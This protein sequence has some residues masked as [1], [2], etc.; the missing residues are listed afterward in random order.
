MQDDCERIRKDL[1]ELF[2]HAYG[3]DLDALL[4]ARGR[5][6]W[7]IGIDSKK[8]EMVDVC[9]M[10]DPQLFDSKIR[11]TYDDTDA[12]FMADAHI[13]LG[14]TDVKA[15]C[16][17]LNVEHFGKGRDFLHPLMV[18]ELAHYLDQIGEDPAASDK[19]KNNAAAM[20]ISMTPNVRNLPAH[21][22]RWAQHLAVGARR[23]VT[24]GQSGHKTIR[25][26]AEAA[27]PWY[28]RRP[29]WDISIRE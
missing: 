21:N 14:I 9:G 11:R 28:D 26:F 2:S 12:G 4:T 5:Q 18:H 29:R 25:E 7:I 20:L 23:L 13:P 6:L 22:H 3:R 10:I 19:D 24:D 15:D 16:F 17:L 27:I 1:A 8:R